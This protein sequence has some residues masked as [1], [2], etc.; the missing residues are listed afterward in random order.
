MAEAQIITVQRQYGNVTLPTVPASYPSI[1]PTTTKPAAGV[2]HD[3]VVNAIS[4]SLMRVLPYS[5]AT[6]IG[7][8]T[9][10]RLVGWN[11]R[12]DSSTGNTTYVPTVL[13]DFSLSFTTGTVPTWSM[14]G[15]TQRPFAVIAQ[16]AGTPAGNL[17]SPGTAAATN[18]EPASAMVDIAGSQMVTVQFRA[19]S[20]T[21]TMGVFVTTL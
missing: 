8:A 4:P 12:I 19:A 10:M 5:A 1:A 2:L 18:V 21:P 16:V 3:Q 20:G 7:A 9:G 15:A 13:A 6:S 14:D 11:I 17:Y